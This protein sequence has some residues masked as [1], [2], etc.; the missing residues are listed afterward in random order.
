MLWAVDGYLW[1]CRVE[2]STQQECFHDNRCQLLL[3]LH[4]LAL[5]R[6]GFILLEEGLVHSYF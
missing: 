1:H 6:Q 3:G 4:Q 2:Y 5:L